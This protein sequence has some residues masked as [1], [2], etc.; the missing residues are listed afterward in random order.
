MW[1]DVFDIQLISNKKYSIEMAKKKT[2]LWFDKNYIFPKI[3][4]G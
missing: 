3:V 1:R 4:E 2:T